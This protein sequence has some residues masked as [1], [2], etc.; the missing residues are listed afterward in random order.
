MYKEID[1]AAVMIWHVEQAMHEFGFLKKD[2]HSIASFHQT[3]LDLAAYSELTQG[4]FMFTEYILNKRS[5]YYFIETG[6]Y[7]GFM[8]SKCR[9]LLCDSTECEADLP[10]LYRVHTPS[11][12]KQR[13]EYIVKRGQSIASKRGQSAAS[14]E[15]GKRIFVETVIMLTSTLTV[16]YAMYAW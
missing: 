4:V 12:I 3:L 8:H 2:N 11:D 14:K 13:A 6:S 9:Q 10:L 7:I 15:G 16:C 1:A 5:V